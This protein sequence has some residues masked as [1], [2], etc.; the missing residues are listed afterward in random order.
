MN[1]NIRDLLESEASQAGVSIDTL[2]LLVRPVLKGAILQYVTEANIELV[3]DK[4]LAKVDGWLSPTPAESAAGM[5]VSAHY[6][7]LAESNVVRDANGDPPRAIPVG[8][9][10]KIVAAILQIIFG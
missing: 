1:E 7:Q 3:L 2:W 5:Y 4:V 8:T 6:E 10:V 9:I